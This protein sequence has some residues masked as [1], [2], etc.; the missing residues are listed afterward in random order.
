MDVCFQLCSMPV[1]NVILLGVCVYRGNEESVSTVSSLPEA[2]AL[3]FRYSAVQ[4]KDE[5][6]L[7]IYL[8]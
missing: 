7:Y 5:R 1:K 4:L 6:N 8:K 3:F 2:A